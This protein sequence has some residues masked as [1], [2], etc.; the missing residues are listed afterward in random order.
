MLINT[1]VA[2]T[3]RKRT[4]FSLIQLHVALLVLCFEH[5]YSPRVG[6]FAAH[7]Y[8]SYYKPTLRILGGSMTYSYKQKSGQ[9]LIGIMFDF[10]L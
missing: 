7:I 4:F 10:Y 8:K 3:G 9:K 2:V 5:A 1:Y 6:V